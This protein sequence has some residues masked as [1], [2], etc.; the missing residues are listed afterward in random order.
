VHGVSELIFGCG[1]IFAGMASGKIIIITAPSGAGKTS[2]TQYLLQQFPQLTFSISAT[3]RAPRGNEVHGREYYFLTESEFVQ[4]RNAGEFL[5]WEMVYKGKYYG[6]LKSE[7]GRI[8]AAEKVPVLDIDVK[9]AIQVQAEYPG[10]CLSIFIRVPSVEELRRRLERRGTET[11][12]SMQTR[13]DKAEY[14]MSF[15]HH[16][17][18]VVV[19][20]QLEKAQAEAATLVEAFLKA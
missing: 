1:I 18:A 10:Q 2:I 3:T 6:T 5:E 16:F 9:G 11:P 20:D 7:M 14:E 4:R 19:N 12:E 13:L 15:I 8:W 17:N